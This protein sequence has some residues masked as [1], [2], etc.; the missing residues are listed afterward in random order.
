MRFSRPS[1]K[2]PGYRLSK[3]KLRGASRR[4]IAGIDVYAT[5]C[6]HPS[7]RFSSD[8]RGSCHHALVTE[9]S[10]QPIKPILSRPSLVAKC[11]RTVFGRKLGSE[12]PRSQNLSG[13]DI[14]STVCRLN[15]AA[16][17]PRTR[18]PREQDLDPSRD[19]FEKAG[20]VFNGLP[21]TATQ[22]AS[23][24]SSIFRSSK[25]PSKGS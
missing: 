25:W 12:L 7:P 1:R 17:V 21:I 13:R 9:T 2:A 24:S 15:F 19:Y 6:L 5:L 16:E 11:Q 8:K 14:A 22:L 3:K 18:R 10:D 23:R 4:D 20:R